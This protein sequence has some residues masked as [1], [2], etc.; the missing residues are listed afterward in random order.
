MDDIESSFKALLGRQ[1]SD[2]EVERLYRVK[3]ALNIRDND[4]MW[5]I[6]MALESYD[7]LYSKYPALI[8][9][10]VDVVIEKQR[11]LIAEIVDAE[12]KKALS[13]LSSAVAQTSQLVAMKVADTA[14]WQAWG[15]VCV[16]L[17]AFGA[18]CLTAGFI[19]GSGNM[20]FWASTHQS[21]NPLE[22]VIS[23]L[24]KAPVGWLV[25]LISSAVVIVTL[26]SNRQVRIKK[27]IIISLIMMV[28]LSVF[29]IH[30]II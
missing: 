14:R 26:A 22:I 10:Q 30:T 6:L 9:G 25:P 28:V 12:S 24:M 2:K 16:G 15:W 1:P 20:P 18:L 5:M 3:N 8:A 13:T 11:E 7:T 19:L 23:I 4:A 29:C 27:P 17:I 21:S